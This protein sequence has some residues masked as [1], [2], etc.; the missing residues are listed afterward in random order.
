M[1]RFGGPPRLSCPK[2]NMAK[3]CRTWRY[4]SSERRAEV[5]LTSSLPARPLCM[6]ALQSSRACWW[7]PTTFHWGRHLCLTYSP[8]HKGP[9]QWRN[10]PPQL[11]L[12][13]QCPSSLLGPNDDTLPQ[14]LWTAHLWAELHLRQLQKGPL[15]PSSERSH[16]GTKCSSQ[17]MKRHLAGT[18]TW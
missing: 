6:P 16:H 9:L 4:N 8:Y 18:L 2:G 17:A 3:S 13:H 5:K 11:P 15:A 10:S 14:I 12:P 7:L 1:L